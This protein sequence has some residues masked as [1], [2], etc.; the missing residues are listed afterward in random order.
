M[1]THTPQGTA[2]TK[3]DKS[4]IY[5]D[6]FSFIHRNCQELGLPKNNQQK[7]NTHI[8]I[9]YFVKTVYICV[10]PVLCHILRPSFMIFVIPI[11]NW[12]WLLFFY[13]CFFASKTQDPVFMVS[14]A[15]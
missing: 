8:S 2:S 12:L 9:G 15:S 7:F 6:V 14:I 4:R 10:L 3:H 11:T 13:L 5:P 1:R